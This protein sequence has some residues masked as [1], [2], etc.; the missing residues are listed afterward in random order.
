M[1]EATFAFYLRDLKSLTS[2]L[3][4]NG[5]VETNSDQKTEKPTDLVNAQHWAIVV[6]F[7]GTEI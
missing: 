6:H 2:S 4:Q 7:P 5:E 1:K 3:R